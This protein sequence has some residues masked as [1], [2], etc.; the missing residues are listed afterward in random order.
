MAAVVLVLA[1]LSLGVV[2]MSG[3]GY[4]GKP[5]LRDAAAGGA[6]SGAEGDDGPGNDAE[7]GTEGDGSSTAEG[8]ERESGAEKGNAEGSG[9]E[10]REG[11]RPAGVY[12]FHE[13]EGN[14]LEP[15]TLPVGQLMYVKLEEYGSSL[16]YFDGAWNELGRLNQGD[17]LEVL[18]WEGEMA[19][20]YYNEDCDV[21]YVE[22][23]F[24]SP[25][26][27]GRLVR[28]AQAPSLPPE[29]AGTVSIRIYK[30]RRD[31]ELLSDGEVI[32]TYSVGLGGWPWDTKNVKG[33]SRTPEGSYYVCVRN[34]NSRFHLAL[35]LS[36]PN[37][38]DA[39]RGLENGVITKKQKQAIDRAIDAGEKPPWNTGLGGEIM[40]HGASEDGKGAE[41][42]WT[43][44]CIAVEDAVIDILWE[45]CRLGTEVT[46]EP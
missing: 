44:G 17:P 11:E 33:D 28:P 34:A 20:V 41:W 4:P 25:E 8:A 3:P 43:A 32:A 39:V 13:S 2:L 15:E 23:R 30:E 16:P 37:K 27:P 21:A 6:Q 26:Q 14:S 40:I 10:Q 1:G 42:D 45:Y 24:L 7:S 12:K 19:P 35:G 9:A 5:W 38:E 18:P 36:Y 31:L 46:I 22:A 29:E